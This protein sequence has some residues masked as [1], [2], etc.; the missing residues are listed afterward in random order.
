[1]HPMHTIGAI[2]GPERDDLY[3]DHVSSTYGGLAM[4]GTPDLCRGMMYRSTNCEDWMLPPQAEILNTE[5]DL[6][7]RLLAKSFV[8]CFVVFSNNGSVP[9]AA[10]P[11]VI[12]PVK[13]LQPVKNL[14]RPISGLS[15]DLG[16][17]RRT[18]E[19]AQI[20]PPAKTPSERIMLAE[21]VLKDVQSTLLARESKGKKNV[22]G[23][24]STDKTSL[25]RRRR[26][27]LVCN[28]CALYEKLHGQPRPS[29][30]LNQ[31]IRRRNRRDSSST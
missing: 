3:F 27:I 30:L 17:A 10:P 15:A 22:C 23:H 7:E 12:S 8:N 26:G 28:A 19:L 18:V 11:P 6:Y 9:M 24:C 4:A 21:P 20:S 5:P 14:R 31:M 2:T 13:N 1:M 25:W 16:Q 29:H